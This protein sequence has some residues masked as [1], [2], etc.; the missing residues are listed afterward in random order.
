MLKFSEQ[1]EQLRKVVRD[2]VEKE[3]ATI[4]SKIDQEDTCPV[5]L[6]RMTAQLGYNGVFV[7]ECYQGVGLGYT[8]R[9]IILE[10]IA[11][12][13]AGFAL[14]LMTHHLGVYAILTWGNEEQKQK[15]LPKLCSGSIAGLAVTEPG[16]GSDFAG[17][18]STGELVDGYWVL[19]GRKCFITNSHCADINIVV[20][21]TG[22]DEKGRPRMSVFVIDENTPGCKPGRKEKKT[23]LKG[24]DMGDVILD[25][26]KV[27]A[28]NLIGKPGDGAKI[29]LGTI[30]EVG[31][32]GMAAIGLGI[33]RA[34]LEDSVK[35]AK[36]RIIYGRPLAKLTN[37]QFIIAQNRT[38]YE[39]GRLLT[40]NAVGIKDAG[41]PCV[42]EIS[43]A[44]Y[45]TT[46]AAINTAK[47]TIDLMG[48]YGVI[49]DYPVDRYLRDAVASIPSGGTSYVMQIIIAGSALS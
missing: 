42:P 24:S 25:N 6:L 17:M 10:E 47:R 23:G 34:C 3:I 14:A 13:S 8:E 5:E 48:G 32:S 15:Y 35:F 9:A 39:A 40:Y 49:C 18:K 1:Q 26:V 37:I 30:S 21:R 20:V 16:G 28:S 29:G 38:D 31:R 46:E 11:R 4:A 45:F 44:K 36:E 19:N 22:E 27:P 33:L 2:F 7:P 43:I 41:L 12:H